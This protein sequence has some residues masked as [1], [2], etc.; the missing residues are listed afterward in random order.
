MGA[1]DHC[2]FPSFT[3]VF[4]LSNRVS[5]GLRMHSGF[6]TTKLSLRYISNRSVFSMINEG[7]RTI[8][9]SEHNLCILCAYYK[10]NI[11]AM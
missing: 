7:R 6:L 11:H 8:G 4:Q 1:V 10:F 2:V 3:L 5:I 9:D